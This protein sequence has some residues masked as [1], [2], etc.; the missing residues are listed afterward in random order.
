MINKESSMENIEIK[1][2][3]VQKSCGICLSAEKDI[4]NYITTVLE[5]NHRIRGAYIYNT[6]RKILKQDMNAYDRRYLT[7]IFF[8]VILNLL[9]LSVVE[10]FSKFKLEIPLFNSIQQIQTKDIYNCDE[11]Q[12]LNTSLQRRELKSKGSNYPIVISMPYKINNK[13][14]CHGVPKVS[15]IVM[16]HTAPKHFTRRIVLRSKMLNATYYS[17]ESV[18]V[19]FL[20]GLVKSEI[21]QKKIEDESETYGDDEFKGIKRYP[22]TY[23]SGLV[24]FIS[25]DLVPML[26]QAAIGS[27]FV[28]VDDF[29]LFGILP[30]KVD[31]V[32]HIDLRTRLNFNLMKA[33]RCYTAYGTKCPHAVVYAAYHGNKG[34][35]KLWT[36]IVKDR[37]QSIYGNYYMNLPA[38]SNPKIKPL[39]LY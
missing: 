21:I 36:A 15:T 13:N 25:T 33:V 23:C 32:V 10:D 2:T 11:D 38:F 34:F 1:D 4:V 27:P 8:I 22:H 9:I 39:S 7:F 30:S 5:M 6:K 26:Y 17:P 35:D 24:V 31:G 3:F 29:Y 14:I 28:W 19:V 12:N 16:V 37:Q 18:R 20:L